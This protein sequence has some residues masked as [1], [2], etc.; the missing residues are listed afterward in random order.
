MAR[1]SAIPENLVLPLLKEWEGGKTA[2]QLVIWLEQTHSI[3]FISPQAGIAAVNRRIK[4]VKDVEMQAKRDAVAKA[5]S[6]QVIDFVSMINKKI[7]KLDRI[8]DNLLDKDNKKDHI[9]AKALLETQLKYIDKQTN[10]MG[11]DNQTNES[12]DQDA[13]VDGLID[14]LGK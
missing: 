6:E 2:D 12:A 7:A 11:M 9:L 5:A 10:L 1:Q 3:R 4:A 14:K 13:L 8:T